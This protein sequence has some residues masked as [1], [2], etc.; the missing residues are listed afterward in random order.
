MQTFKKY[1]LEEKRKHK[2]KKK[3]KKK[4]PVAY[5]LAYGWPNDVMGDGDVG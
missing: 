4:A 3:G 1:Y 2:K 5:Y